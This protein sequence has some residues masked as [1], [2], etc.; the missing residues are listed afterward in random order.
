MNLI[1]SHR[2][3]QGKLRCKWLSNVFT[4]KY[5]SRTEEYWSAWFFI[6]V[7]VILLKLVIWMLYLIIVWKLK[8]CWAFCIHLFIQNLFILNNISPFNL[9]NRM[10][11]KTLY[12]TVFWLFLQF[13]CNN[14]HVALQ[15]LLP[16]SLATIF[17]NLRLQSF[18]FLYSFQALNILIA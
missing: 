17:L 2:G 13:R 8:Y 16:L 5:L 15:Q 1:Y 11:Q 4:W 9:N 14:V 12:Q 3:M 18:N 10:G 6:F 7:L